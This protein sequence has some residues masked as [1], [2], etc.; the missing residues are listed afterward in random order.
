MAA[1]AA[2]KHLLS[3]SA[4]FGHASSCQSGKVHLFARIC[5][6]LV[7]SDGSDFR[8]AADGQERNYLLETPHALYRIQLAL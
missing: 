4:D 3:L 6:P 2:P 1:F 5:Y 8:L 7:A